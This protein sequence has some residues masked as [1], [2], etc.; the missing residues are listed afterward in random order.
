MSGNSTGPGGFLRS[1][2]GDVRGLLRSEIRAT[3]D[4]ITAKVSA[5]LR[6]AGRGTGLLAGAGAL[7]AVSLGLSAVLVLRLLEAFLPPRTAAFVAT[8]LYGSGAAAL[9]SAGVAE[10]RRSRQRGSLVRVEPTRD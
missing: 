3:Q 8:A 2:G 7:G 6:A 5:R 9:G 1:V 10:L 4:D